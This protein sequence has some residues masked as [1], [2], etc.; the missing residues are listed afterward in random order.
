MIALCGNGSME[1]TIRTHGSALKWVE[2]FNESVQVVMT[3]ISAIL[4]L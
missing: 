1:V 4:K 2:L 3:K